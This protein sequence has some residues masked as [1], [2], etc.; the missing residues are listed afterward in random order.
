MLRLLLPRAT[1]NS[2]EVEMG[3][4]YQVTG[5]FRSGKPS[6]GIVTDISLLQLEAVNLETEFLVFDIGGG[7]GG[8]LGQPCANI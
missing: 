5:R 1:L 7:D 6:R 4:Q 2:T 3:A 8:L